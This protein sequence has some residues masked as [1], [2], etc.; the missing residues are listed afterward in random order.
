MQLAINVDN[1]KNFGS[2]IFQ[3]F[4]DVATSAEVCAGHGWWCSIYCFYMFKSSH[5]VFRN[6]SQEPLRRFALLRTEV[7]AQM[8]RFLLVKHLS[9]NIYVNL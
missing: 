9:V 1:F 4:Y 6:M 8:V 2:D 5:C 3:T 7:T